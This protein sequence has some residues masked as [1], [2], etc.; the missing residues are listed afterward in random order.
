MSTNQLTDIAAGE[1]A[2]VIDRA[3]QYITNAK[4]PA[5]RRAY[6]A[7]WADFVGWC[8]RNGV[9]ALPTTP[10]VIALYLA[11]QA[12]KG[13]KTSTLRRRIAAIAQAHRAAGKEPVSLRVEPLHSTWQ[14]ILRVHGTAQQGKSPVWTEHLRRMV[15]E[16]PH[17]MLGVRDR[18]LLLLGFAGGMRRSELVGLNVE[19]LAFEQEGLILSI[20]RSKTDQ[21]GEGRLVGIPY[22]SRLDTCPLRAVQ[23]WLRQSGLTAGPLFRYV[24]RHGNVGPKRLSGNAVALVVQRYAVAAGLKGDFAG[25]SLRAGLATTAAANGVQERSIAKQTGHRSLEVLRRYIRDG[26]LF[27]QNAAASVGL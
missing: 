2:A 21:T 25:H 1:L 19:D 23:T 9:V 5:T 16:L 17:N 15:A 10:Q 13:K 18:A 27:R 7:D 24:D 22:G 11:A 20:R 12:G 4:A 26:D 6:R 3:H 14:G 8:E